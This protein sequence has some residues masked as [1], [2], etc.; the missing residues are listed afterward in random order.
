MKMNNGLS[1]E[2]YGKLI[3]VLYDR[4]QALGHITMDMHV[5]LEKKTN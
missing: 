1:K 4:T 2:A 3:V 5:L